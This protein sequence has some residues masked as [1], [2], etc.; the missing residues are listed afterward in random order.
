MSGSGFHDKSA[1]V[2][3]NAVVKTADTQLPFITDILE[4]SDEAGAVEEH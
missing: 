1:E 4:H 3:S 2:V